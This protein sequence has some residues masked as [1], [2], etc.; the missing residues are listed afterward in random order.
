M[1]WD[2]LCDVHSWSDSI[3]YIRVNVKGGSDTYTPPTGGGGTT[4]TIDV[5]GKTVNFGHGGRHL[6]GTGLD[7]NKVNQTLADEVSKLN[8]SKGEFYKGQ[9]VVDGITIEFT[10]YGLGDD[11]INVGTY[12][13]IGN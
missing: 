7:V 9:I 12:Y 13:P 4:A 11:A 3:Y 2:Q 8:L 5:N 6:E 1:N 10:S